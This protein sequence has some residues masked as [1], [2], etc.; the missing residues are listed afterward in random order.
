MHRENWGENLQEVYKPTVCVLDLKSEAVAVAPFEEN[1]L[2]LAASDPVWCPQ[3]EGIV[4]VG[5]S[6]NAYNLGV[7]YC[8]Q[9]LCRI[10]YWDISE[11]FQFDSMTLLSGSFGLLYL[12]IYS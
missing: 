7:T 4:F 5:Y 12:H 3:D 2:N 1:S 9:R 11:P 8:T 10:Y 6:L